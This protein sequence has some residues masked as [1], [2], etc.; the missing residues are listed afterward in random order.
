M[1][2][3]GSFGPQAGGEVMAGSIEEREIQDSFQEALEKDNSS[4]RKEIDEETY[5][6]VK[7]IEAKFGDDPYMLA[8]KVQ[9]MRDTTILNLFGRVRDN[10]RGKANG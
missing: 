5:K 1:G 10:V 8:I 9:D 4:R 2:M 7:K 6:A 3:I